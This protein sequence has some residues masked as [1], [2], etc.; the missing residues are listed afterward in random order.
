MSKN[1]SRHLENEILK[2]TMA[3]KDQYLI[4][5]LINVLRGSVRA[6]EV[7]KNLKDSQKV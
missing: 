7:R 5:S 3:E 1:S 4:P 2:V 6:G